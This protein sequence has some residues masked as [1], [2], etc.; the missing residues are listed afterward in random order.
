MIVL[1]TRRDP[2]MRICTSNNGRRF[3]DLCNEHDLGY[4]SSFKH[5]HSISNLQ[6][7]CCKTWRCL[8]R[9]QHN[10]LFAP[11]PKVCKH[12]TSFSSELWWLTN[13]APLLSG[14][15]W[16]LGQCKAK[17]CPAVFE[18]RLCTCWVPLK[19][20]GLACRVSR[21]TTLI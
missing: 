8:L 14:R 18:G 12:S 15:L 11:P 13:E 2:P 17:R 19:H 21:H 6:Q 16:R 20:V 3:A 5:S 9:V 7:S 10:V 4:I 1:T